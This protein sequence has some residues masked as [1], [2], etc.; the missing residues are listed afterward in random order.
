[1]SVPVSLYS[2]KKKNS[3]NIDT[4]HSRSF[5]S[6][7]D[8]N[9]LTE[10]PERVIT[11]L[12][13]SG[14]RVL[15]HC[16]LCPFWVW[17]DPA[18]FLHCVGLAWSSACWT[19]LS[20]KYNGPITPEP[21]SDWCGNEKT[22]WSATWQ[23]A[24]WTLFCLRSIDYPYI[25]KSVRSDSGSSIEVYT[26]LSKPLLHPLCRSLTQWCLVTG[27][28]RDFRVKATP[29]WNLCFLWRVPHQLQLWCPVLPYPCIYSALVF[30]WIRNT[31]RMCC[32]MFC[33]LHVNIWIFHNQC[34]TVLI[35]GYSIHKW[36]IK[37]KQTEQ[38]LRKLKM[39]VT[40]QLM[41]IK[42]SLQT[43]VYLSPLPVESRLSL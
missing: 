39:S 43:S 20:F 18:L 34:N 31:N 40:P 12:P 17:D 6:L 23:S 15:A 27:R 22:L 29:L 1:M 25:L 38:L 8:G 14:H 37:F 11:H 16:S 13:V 26:C 36:A 35:S 42:N 33:M 19:Q 4:L 24:D 41:I 9:E 21:T 3:Q 30:F 10:S 28:K 32:R 5:T 7:Q 2:W